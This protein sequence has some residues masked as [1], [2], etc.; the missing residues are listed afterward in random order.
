MAHRQLQIYMLKLRDSCQE[1]ALYINPAQC[2]GRDFDSV[3][4]LFI[5]QIENGLAFQRFYGRFPCATRLVHAKDLMINVKCTRCGVVNILSNEICKACGLE[6]SPTSSAV[7]YSEPAPY[8]RS[9][10]SPTISSI[11]PFN[12]VGEVLAPSITLFSRNFWVITKLVLVIVTP[13][14]IFRALSIGETAGDW[15]LTLGTLALQAFCSVLI[16][17]ALIY[18]LMKVMQTG[19]APGVNESYRWGLSKLGKLLL[20]TL[21]VWV[22]VMFGFVLLIIPGIILFLAFNLVY[23]IAVL[24]GGSPT[25]ILTRSYNLTKGHRWNILGATFVMSILIAFANAPGTMLA[26]WLV[27]SGFD[28]WPI[29]AL[30][31]IISDILGQAATVLSLIIYLSILRT[32]ES[33]QS[34]IE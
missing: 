13:F 25:E 23:P 33:R 10:T 12:G 31:A 34:L 3:A 6:L 21:M 7:T 4:K 14:E 24:E 11:R 26:A 19:V 2:R 20:C 18:A 8:R 28:F 17:P 29:Q 16:A 32:L 5:D 27:L 15:Q 30:V 22:L 1:S 9:S